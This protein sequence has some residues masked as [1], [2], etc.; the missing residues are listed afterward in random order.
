MINHT[1]KYM[2]IL[3]WAIGIHLLSGIAFLTKSSFESVAI[4]VGMNQLTSVFGVQAI[5]V[6]LLLTSLISV[7]AILYA[8]TRKLYL[9][10]IAPQYLILVAAVVAGATIMVT[11]T[12]NGVETDRLLAFYA[13]FPMLWATVLNLIALVR[14]QV[15]V[16]L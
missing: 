13:L 12:N 2:F 10:C 4:L 15:R 16:P 3:W 5:G 1:P 9:L 11:G 14:S 7:W 6:V 8:R